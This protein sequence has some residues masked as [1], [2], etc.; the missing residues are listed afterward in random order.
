M[1]KL[2]CPS[3][4]AEVTF[5][6]KASVFAVCSYC[7][8]TMVRQ[9]M[10]LE[11]LGKM[12]DLQDDLTPLQ[13]GTQGQHDGRLFEI[14]GRLKIAYSDGYWNEW[15][16][17]FGGDETG[18]LAEVQGFYAVCFPFTAPGIYLPPRKRAKPGVTVELE[19]AGTFEIVD[20]RDVICVFSEGELPLNAAQGRESFSVDLTGPN[21]QMGTIEYAES[22]ERTYIG[23][24]QD[25]DTFKFRNLRA[26][27]GW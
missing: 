6:S 1:I 7:K 17:L 4:G 23:T 3:C 5:Q 2:S 27:D 8:S 11:L 15:Y 25:F 14:I 16:T 21:D 9:D 18:W 24:Y 20:A 19:P 26:I 22:M 10:N 13:L 12:S